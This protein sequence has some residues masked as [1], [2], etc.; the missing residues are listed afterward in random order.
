[1]IAILFAVLSVATFRVWAQTDNGSEKAELLSDEEILKCCKW[2]VSTVPTDDP[3]DGAMRRKVAMLI[4]LYA[5]N[6]E[7]FTLVVGGQVFDVIGQSDDNQRPELLLVYMA[8]EIIYCMEH[9]L[10]RNTEDSFVSAMDGLMN[11][12]SLLPDQPVKSVNKYLK[13]EPSAR[14]TALRKRYR[15]NMK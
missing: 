2:Y 13:M 11:Y 14:E 5:I 15:K 7:N 8:G 4:T 6:S 1:M 12:Y 10:S 3:T 9:N